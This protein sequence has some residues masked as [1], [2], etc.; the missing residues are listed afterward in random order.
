[1]FDYSIKYLALKFKDRI[2]AIVIIDMINKLFI[3]NT[4]KMII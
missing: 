4:R 2:S 3:L 1:M